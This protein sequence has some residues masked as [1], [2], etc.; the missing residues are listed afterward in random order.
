MFEVG[1]VF[2]A[3]NSNTR[4]HLWE[5]TGLEE[6]KWVQEYHPFQDI[7]YRKDALRLTFKE[8][9]DLLKEAGIEQASDPVLCG[10]F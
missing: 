10:I 2:R 6:I 1:P 9:C 3:K 8:G 7:R 5:V 4:R